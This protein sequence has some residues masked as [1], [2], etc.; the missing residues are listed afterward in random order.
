ME[1]HS[2]WVKIKNGQT[3]AQGEEVVGEFQILYE[4]AESGSRVLIRG[5]FKTTDLKEDKWGYEILEDAKREE[6]NTPFCGG[7]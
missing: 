7:N 6:N 1:V 5:D 4:G 3:I 2:S